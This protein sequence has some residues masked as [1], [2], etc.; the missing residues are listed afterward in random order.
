[1]GGVRA[2]GKGAKWKCVVGGGGDAVSGQTQKLQH[3]GLTIPCTVRFLK[4]YWYFV[5]VEK[6]YYRFFKALT[7][8]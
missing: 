2:M 7:T 8:F 1:M 3:Q 4:V 6:K 5:A